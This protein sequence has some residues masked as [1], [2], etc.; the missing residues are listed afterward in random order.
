[1]CEAFCILAFYKKNMYYD[2]DLEDEDGCTWQPESGKSEGRKKL[3][4]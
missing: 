2:I 3:I 1:V 4:E